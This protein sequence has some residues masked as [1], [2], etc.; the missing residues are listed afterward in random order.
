LKPARVES[1][2]LRIVQPDKSA[3]EHIVETARPGEVEYV[4]DWDYHNA[5]LW[6]SYKDFNTG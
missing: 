3:I 6:R 5:Y 2:S 4:D 1:P